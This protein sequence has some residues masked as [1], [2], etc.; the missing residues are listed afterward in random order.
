M[1]TDILK[2]L[3]QISQGLG[4]QSSLDEINK[5]VEKYKYLNKNEIAA[6]YSWVYEK[7]L[8]DVVSRKIG[9]SDFNRGFRLLSEE[10]ADHIGVENYDYLIHFF[11][12]GLLNNEDLEFII[13]QLMLF[14]EEEISKDEINTLILAIFLDIYNL[15]L[16]GSRILLYTSDTIN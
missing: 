15:D 2:V 5:Q 8:R 6:A 9:I 3:V 13:K 4:R 11:N 7:L 1:Y 10:E 12:A 16:P 14:P